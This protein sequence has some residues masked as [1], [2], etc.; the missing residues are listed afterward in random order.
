[1]SQNHAEEKYPLVRVD[2]LP[3]APEFGQR[4]IFDGKIL[5]WMGEWVNYLELANNQRRHELQMQRCKVIP[6]ESTNRTKPSAVE[7]PH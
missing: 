1:M 5:V 7:M 3:E 2:A 6:N 4:F